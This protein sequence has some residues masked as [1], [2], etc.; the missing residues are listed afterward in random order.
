MAFTISPNWTPTDVPVTLQDPKAIPWDNFG[1]VKRKG[2]NE[3]TL[4]NALA[5]T[6][7]PDRFRFASSAVQNVY[8]STGIDPAYWL[9]SHRGTSILCQLTDVYTA[10]D[11][12]S[13]ISYYLPLSAH[14]VLKVPNTDILTLDDI[15]TFL[16]RLI[17]GLSDSK[18]SLKSQL[19]RLLRGIITP[20]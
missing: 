19:S 16:M 18:G 3:F 5:P 11:A 15:E 12:T 10:A 6:D 20:K 7:R 9:P 8:E 4:N 14:L 17:A 1:I 2:D 13:G